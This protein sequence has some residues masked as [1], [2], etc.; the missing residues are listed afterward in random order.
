[1]C[2]LI[3]VIEKWGTTKVGE[4]VECLCAGQTVLYGIGESVGYWFGNLVT[5][6]KTW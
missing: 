3:T 2:V 5:C 6:W 1:M 4:F